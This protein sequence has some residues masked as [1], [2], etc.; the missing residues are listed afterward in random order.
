MMTS[1]LSGSVQSRT[2]AHDVGQGGGSWWIVLSSLIAVVAS[3][4]TGCATET[5]ESPVETKVVGG[6][7]TK[8]FGGSADDASNAQSNVV[9]LKV[10]TEGNYQLCSG[11]LIAANVVLTARHCVAKSITSTVSCDEN[12]NSTN[13]PHV[14]GNH[15]PREISVFMG[16]SPKFSGKADAMAKQV[17]SPDSNTLCDNDIALIVLDTALQNVAPLAVRLGAAKAVVGGEAIRSVGYGQNNDALPL[18][19]RMRKDGVSILAMGRG[20]S[21]SNTALGG[22]EFEVGESICEGDSGGP[23]ISEATG[24]VIGVVSR[25]GGCDDN[26]GH[27]YTATTAFKDLVNQAFVVAGG[28]PTVEASQPAAT[29]ADTTTVVMANEPSASESDSGAKAQ[30]GGC[31]ASGVPVSGKTGGLLGLGLVGMLVLRRRRR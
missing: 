31:S 11:A 27:I 1:T 15:D 25:G 30:A 14:D 22:N 20:V 18:G 19:T 10:G 26:F 28:A 13:G 17:I 5:T 21:A 24:A 16:E 6:E 12:G 9:A 2:S 7:E 8:I 23:A 4:C 3:I 29:T